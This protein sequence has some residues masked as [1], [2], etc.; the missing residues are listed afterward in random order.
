MS[1]CVSLCVFIECVVNVI[2]WVLEVDGFICLKWILLI[3]FWVLKVVGRAK[4]MAKGLSVVTLQSSWRIR[5]E[6]WMKGR[7]GASMGQHNT[8]KDQNYKEQKYPF[9]NLK[10]LTM[11]MLGTIFKVKYKPY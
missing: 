6:E 5:G 8:V 2:L 9:F 4:I 10:F 3:I 11:L 1:L 7:V